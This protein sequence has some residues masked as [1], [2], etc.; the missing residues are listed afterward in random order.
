MPPEAHILSHGILT[1]ET[2][3]KL[4]WRVQSGISQTV[5]VTVARG[6]ALSANT[7]EAVHVH[8]GEWS[9]G[10]VQHDHINTLCSNDYTTLTL[11]D[12]SSTLHI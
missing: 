7:K 2:L 10:K 5:T 1:W 8:V 3:Y 11:L 4:D 6:W 12:V 9:M